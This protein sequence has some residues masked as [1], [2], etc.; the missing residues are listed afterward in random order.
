MLGDSIASLNLVIQELRSFMTGHSL[1][2]GAGQSLRSE[3]EKAVR[4]AGSR[5]LAFTVDIDPA[6]LSFLTDEQSLQLLQ[7]AREC[8]SNAARHSGAR[9]GHI[10]LH[11]QDGGVHFE[12]SDDGRGFVASRSKQL[13]FGLRHIDARARKIGGKARFMSAPNQGARIIV[14]IGKV[15]SGKPPS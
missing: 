8:I 13:G 15:S 14:R 7:I 3:I 10:S 1:Q 9:T 11:K 6:T 2:M 12:V 5:G 4:A